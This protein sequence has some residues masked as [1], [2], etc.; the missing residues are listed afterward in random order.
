[1]EKSVFFLINSIDLN[2]GGLTKACIQQANIS[3]SLGF[4]TYILTFD[5]N[6]KFTELKKNIHTHYGLDKDV[7]IYNMYEFFQN[8]SSINK[9]NIYLKQVV[10]SDYC[11][12]KV[13][14]KN[15]FRV[16]IHG[17]Y[18]SYITYRN[19]DTIKGRDLFNESKYRIKSEVYTKHG[20]IGKV[21]YMDLNLNTPRQMKFLDSNGVCYLSKWVNPETKNANKVLLF[22][23]NQIEAVFKNDNQLKGYF[24]EQLIKNLDNPILISDSRKTDPVLIEVN[25]TKAK[26]VIRLHSNHVKAPFGVDSEIAPTVTFALNNL[27]KIDNMLVLTDRQKRDIQSRFTD[28]EKIISI[29]H[30]IKIDSKFSFFKPKKPER[31]NAVVISRLVNLKQID[32]T[33]KAMKIVIEK[34]PNF[35]L[36]IYG[37]GKDE[38]QLRNLVVSEELTNNIKFLGYTKN[39]SDIYKGALFSI[40]TSKT[41]GFSL[42]ILESMSVGTPVISYDFNYGPRDIITTDHDGYI[43]EK[44]NISKLADTIISLL[45]HPEKNKEMSYNAKNSI[46]KNFES[47]S[48]LKK[49]QHFLDDLIQN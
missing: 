12:E 47:K 35:I 27:S 25:A 10:G 24:V 43:I 26:K 31:Q 49:W 8:E 29:P 38:L 4:R 1:M 23:E 44:N 30:G 6:G 33:I 45:D 22:K 15:A 20:Y 19:D 17:L 39:V 5:F 34:Y 3:N 9:K 2:R 37:S 13:K 11:T 36:N 28:T 42:A 7:L 18:D 40:N 41:E 48:I 46:K 32:H 16:Y 14:D 21:S